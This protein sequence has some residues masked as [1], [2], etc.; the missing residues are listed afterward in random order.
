[1][2]HLGN[3][4]GGR[5]DRRIAC[6]LTV[7]LDGGH[8]NEPRNDAAGKQNS[9]NSRADDVADA[10][11]FGSDVRAKTCAREPGWASLGLFRPSEDRFHQEGVDAAESEPP[12][13]ASRERAA[14]LPG[15]Q[16]VSTRGAFG[17][18]Q[19]AVL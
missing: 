16:D 12:K 15:D 2:R 4:N 8:H 7:E 17:K 3:G 1:R 19:V 9:G 10:E 5:I 14:A 18:R 11:I 6:E 13:D